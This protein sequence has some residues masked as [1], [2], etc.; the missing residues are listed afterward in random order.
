[1]AKTLGNSAEFYVGTHKVAGVKMIEVDEGE[2]N[3]VESEELSVDDRPDTF[4]GKLSSIGLR[5]LVERDAADTNGQL[6]LI[7][8]FR[9]A[10]TVTAV[11]YPEGHTV[12]NE[13]WSY[14]AYVQKPGAISFENGKI[15]GYE[16]SLRVTGNMTPGTVSA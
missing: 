3:F 8:A 15:P 10:T 2:R 13:S 11:V 1:M 5:V 16:F 7:A 6:A 14:T 4:V 9:A 12:G